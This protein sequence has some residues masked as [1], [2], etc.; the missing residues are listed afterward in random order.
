MIKLIFPNTVTMYITRNRMKSGH[1]RWG[2]A[3]NPTRMSSVTDEPF[4]GTILLSSNLWAELRGIM[5]EENA[6]FPK[7]RVRPKEF[8]PLILIFLLS[9]FSLT[10]TCTYI[11]LFSTCFNHIHPPYPF[12]VYPSLYSFLLFIRLISISHMFLKSMTLHWRIADLP[13]ATLL[14]NID[15]TF[16][17][18]S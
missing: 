2:S 4:S 15:S 3:V 8:I 7:H 18:N 11:M 5:L 14:E 6:A 13:G 12:F 1:W 10:H 16:P 9:K 17:R